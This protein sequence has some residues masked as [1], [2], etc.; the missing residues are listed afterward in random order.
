MTGC[1]GKKRLETRGSK[2]SGRCRAARDWPRQT[3]E[4]Q[5]NSVEKSKRNLM[6][7]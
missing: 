4:R 6:N 2:S 5:D 1:V 7:G 3:G